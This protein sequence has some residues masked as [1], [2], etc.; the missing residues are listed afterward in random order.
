MSDAATEQRQ[1]NKM[2]VMPV[3]KLLLSMS[4]PMMISMLVQ[5]LYNIVDSMFVSMMGKGETGLVDGDAI[6]SLGEAALTAVSLAFP[7]Q[8]LM[9]A[10]AIGTGVGVNAFLSKSLGEKNF[11][12]VN[13]SANNAI[14]LAFCSYA[15]FAVLGILFSR[16]FFEIQTSNM[17]LTAP[18]AR[19]YIVEQGT[20]Y[21]VICTVFS[22]G[23]FF[24]IT[25]ERLLQSTGKTFYTMITQGIGAIINII[26]DPIF[27]FGWLGF[28]EMGTA[29]AAAA[30]VM[31]QIVAAIIAITI[32]VKKNKEITVSMRKFRPDGQIIK[33]IYLVG[34]PS[35]ILAAIG[36]V[37]T[38]GMNKILMLFSSTATAVFGAYFKLQ[39]FVFMPVFGLNNGMVPII[40]YNF[41]ARNPDRI[42][43]TIRLSVI[44]A[45]S[46]MLIGVAVFLFF[47]SQILA[48]FNAGEDMLSIGVPALRIICGHFLFAG[49]CIVTSSVLQAFSH[50]FLSLAV[51]A[52]RQ[53]IVILPAAY[54]LSLTGNINMIWLSFPI[55][56]IVSFTMCIVF[57]HLVFKKEIVPMRSSIAQSSA[58]G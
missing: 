54:F 19:A 37:M 16:P 42:T 29:G 31:G 53:L 23:L 2:G 13:K 38:F 33:R 18:I 50:G 34:V 9:I 12:R 32:N 10:V 48:I 24:Q 45:S 55:A 11:E 14:F 17:A 30:T 39:S 4:I 7:A 27:I 5:A 56:E 26:F 44:Y 36:S 58:I 52:V 25:S 41:G 15:V 40:A 8:S 43:K 21:L 22:F 46:I 1:E 49:F 35:I 51:S 28:P 20:D 3:N 57:M 6:L 47:P